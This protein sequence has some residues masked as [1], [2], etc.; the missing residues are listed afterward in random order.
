VKLSSRKLKACFFL[1]PNTFLNHFYETN[2]S[3]GICKTIA[4][5]SVSNVMQNPERSVP[6]NIRNHP[7]QSDFRVL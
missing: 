6:N 3:V 4:P 7:F 1:M 5:V 2:Y